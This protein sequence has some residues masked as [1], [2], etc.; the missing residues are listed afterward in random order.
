TILAV[1]V[2]AGCSRQP[3]GPTPGQGDNQADRTVSLKEARQ[4]FKTKLVQRESEKEP[5][6]DPPPGVFRKV[7]FDSPVGKLAAYL[8]PDPKD[9]KKHPAIIWI[10]GGDCNSI[11]PLWTEGPAN[12]EQTASAYR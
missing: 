6:P 12:N 8:T 4:G 5:V 9:G 1:L 11:G 7:H 3:S 10:T 2:L